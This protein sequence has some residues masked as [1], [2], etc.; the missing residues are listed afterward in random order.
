MRAAVGA[1]GQFRAAGTELN[2]ATGVAASPT[3]RLI[4]NHASGAMFQVRIDASGGNFAGD[5]QELKDLHFLALCLLAGDGV[6]GKRTS[7][8]GE[9]TCK[10]LSVTI[11]GIEA[12]V[13][14]E[15]IYAWVDEFT[16]A[17][18]EVPAP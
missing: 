11:D 4:E 1:T 13:T 10:S 18:Q 14:G 6:G 7:G 2:L 15:L 12:A 8:L 3:L 9:I 16:A 17:Y 5:S